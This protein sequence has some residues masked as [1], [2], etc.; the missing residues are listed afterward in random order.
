[1]A[2]DNFENTP[3]D[4]DR[5][6]HID[7]NEAAYIYDTFYKEDDSTS[8]SSSWDDG[9]CEN[10]GESGWYPTEEERKKNKAEMD[11][12]SKKIEDAETAK[13]ARLFGGVLLGSLLFA[14]NPVLGGLIVFITIVITAFTN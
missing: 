10:S 1:M 5:N 12:F 7:S 11:A 13:V 9:D 2:Y 4:L 14:L 8:V 3:F 6:G